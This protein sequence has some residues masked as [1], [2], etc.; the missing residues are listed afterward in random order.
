[1]FSVLQD[2][3]YKENKDVT[4]IAYNACWLLQILQT[5]ELNIIY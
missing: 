3:K 5:Y 1:M 4:A 2:Q